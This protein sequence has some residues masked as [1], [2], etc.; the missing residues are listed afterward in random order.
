MKAKITADYGGLL[1]LTVGGVHRERSPA[2]ERRRGC[3]SKFAAAS[4]PGFFSAG[5]QD[6]PTVP[7]I[8]CVRHERVGKERP[9]L[10]SVVETPW[11]AGLPSD[12]KWRWS[13]YRALPPGPNLIRTHP[14]W[15]GR[16]GLQHLLSSGSV[17]RGRA[18]KSEGGW[19]A[20]SEGTLGARNPESRSHPGGTVWQ[21]FGRSLVVAVVA[22][23]QVVRSFRSF[24]SFRSSVRSAPQAFTTR[25]KH[26]CPSLDKP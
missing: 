18:R 21:S 24:R 17:A 4:R 12:L 14:Q 26:L 16:S 20:S 8:K 5:A 11:W 13:S 6:R 9:V 1:R 15:V 2:P 19:A 22:V 10:G 7:R 3:G 23:V 25:R